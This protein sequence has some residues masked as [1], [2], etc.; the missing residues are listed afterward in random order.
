MFNLGIFL[1]YQSLVMIG[2]AFLS[3]LT[4]LVSGQPVTCSIRLLLNHFL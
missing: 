4:S 1:L 3:N 2:A